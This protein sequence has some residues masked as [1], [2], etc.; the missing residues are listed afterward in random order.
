MTELRDSMRRKRN[1][2]WLGKQSNPVFFY[3]VT[4]RL[5]DFSIPVSNWCRKESPFV[6]EEATKTGFGPVTG[7]EEI[8]KKYKLADSGD[9]CRDPDTRARSDLSQA[10]SALAMVLRLTMMMRL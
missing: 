8:R 2:D 9:N 6:D 10:K 1:G 7:S 5:E 3:N 4:D